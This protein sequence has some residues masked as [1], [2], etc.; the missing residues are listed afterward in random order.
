MITSTEPFTIE[1]ITYIN[2]Y[3]NERILFV[4]FLQRRVIKLG[5]DWVKTGAWR[6]L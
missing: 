4:D 5:K 6:I 3:K 1:G 2:Q